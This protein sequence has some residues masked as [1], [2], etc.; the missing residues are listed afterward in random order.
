MSASCF[1]SE[2]LAKLL[3]DS[4]CVGYDSVCM[5]HISKLDLPSYV[6][7]T[8]SQKIEA[9]FNAEK[10]IR[11]KDPSRF[12]LQDPEL[13]EELRK[14]K[15]V[16][17]RNFCLKE[18]E[19]RALLSEIAEDVFK[20]F[21]DPV[22]SLPELLFGASEEKSREELVRS[23]EELDFRLPI[24][25][26]LVEFLSLDSNKSVKKTY[27]MQLLKEA[28]KQV[29]DENPIAAFISE[30]HTYQHFCE[31]IAGSRCETF[32]ADF[33]RKMLANRGLKEFASS[34]VKEVDPS[35]ELSIDQIQNFMERFMLIGQLEES[36][37][38]VSASIEVD[39]FS[40]SEHASNSSNKTKPDIR[41]GI[42][43]TPS[44]YEDTTTEGIKAFKFSRNKKRLNTAPLVDMVIDRDRIE[45][46]PPG[47]YPSL[48]TFMDLK[49]RKLFIKKIFGND[50][51]AFETFVE[52][53]DR[54]ES[55]KEAKAILEEELSERDINIYD[56]NAIKLSDFLFSRYFSNNRF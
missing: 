39:D 3:E 44:Y 5:S 40:A 6:K 48:Y 10:P 29:Y 26:S 28:R 19:I 43:D 20:L 41:P 25:E 8:L 56:R 31:K 42:Q 53:V 35:R 18:P 33:I 7:Y 54:A 21:L 52:K 9:I 50:E 2:G 46:Q 36:E 45:E 4:I 15:A 14:L 22:T 37:D 32:P 24:F 51:K 47:P 11:I 12:H 38:R 1:S 13:I 17:M 55:W 30:L 16:F 34:I 27:L 23:I 49:T